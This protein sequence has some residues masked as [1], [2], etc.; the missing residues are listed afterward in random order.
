MLNEQP[1][2]VAEGL[3]FMM[4]GKHQAWADHMDDIGIFSDSLISFKKW[5]YTDGV[6]FAIETGA[7]RQSEG[8]VIKEWDHKIVV[9]GETGWIFALCVQSPDS[10]GRSDYPL[11]I[12]LHVVADVFPKNIEALWA[13]LYKFKVVFQ[14]CE[15]QDILR[16]EAKSCY[17]SCV[18][19]ITMISPLDE[20]GFELSDRRR[21]ITQ[22][23]NGG[24]VESIFHRFNRDLELFSTEKKV[25]ATRFFRLPTGNEVES[26][27]LYYFELLSSQLK[28]NHLLGWVESSEG[29][30]ADLF[31]GLTDPQQIVGMKHSCL[32]APVLSEV[33]FNIADSEKSHIETFIKLY[34]SE[35]DLN[36]LS[37]F[38][39]DG[40]KKKNRFFYR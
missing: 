38:T 14:E 35:R 22:V 29:E 10:R 36:K 16:E 40:M 2:Q 13:V 24:G 21:F 3:K 8:N 12:A 15:T 39:K 37:L 20:M 34:S 18:Q 32:F 30:F 23:Q 9:K 28:K 5:L 17:E 19:A 11:V 7:W 27:V 33:K 25:N 31:V 6:R 26:L 4:F 1:N